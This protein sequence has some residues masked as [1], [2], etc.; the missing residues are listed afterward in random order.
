[1][2]FDNPFELYKV[3]IIT[4]KGV[5]KSKNPVPEN[6]QF[7]F[8]T[9]PKIWNLNLPV[10]LPKNGWEINNFQQ[11]F[12]TLLPNTTIMSGS[13]SLK[14]IEIVPKKKAKKATK[15]SKKGEKSEGASTKGK[16]DEDD[17]I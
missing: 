2:K 14:F 12:Q 8:Q 13:K 3:F 4:G 5:V 16:E 7:K 17:S 1:M 10:F 11:N 6:Y 15:G 9:E